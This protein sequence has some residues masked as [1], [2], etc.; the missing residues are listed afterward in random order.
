MKEVISRGAEAVLYEDNEFLVKERVSKGYRIK[1]I[2]S[3]VRKYRTRSEAKLIEKAS[4]VVRVPKVIDSSDEKAI[5]KME[6][7]KGQ[8]IRDILDKLSTNKRVEICKKIGHDIRKLHDINV[9]HGDLTTSNMFL[10]DDEVVFIDFG[11]GFVS[12]KVEDK[13]VDL[14]LLR[15]ALESKHY[16]HFEECNKFVLEGYGPDKQ[17]LTR[18]EKV[19]GRG[20]YKK[21]IG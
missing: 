18:L 13:A 15:Q 19:E 2:D 4:K 20:R 14:H 7:I 21:Q 10:V 11:L 6:F 12:E 17:F 3:K 16:N 5:I 1:E 9:I 8:L